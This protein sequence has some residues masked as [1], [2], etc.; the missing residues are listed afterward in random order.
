MEGHGGGSLLGGRA[1]CPRGQHDPRPRARRVPGV[2]TVSVAPA[3]LAAFSRTRGA[4]GRGRAEGT[5]QAECSWNWPECTGSGSGHPCGRRVR[6]QGAGGRK[7]AK[8][9]TCLPW[10]DSL[11]CTEEAERLL[12]HLWSSWLVV[13]AGRV[14]PGGRGG[15]GRTGESESRESYQPKGTPAALSS[16]YS[17]AP[18]PLT[19][20]PGRASP[21]C[22][23]GGVWWV[24]PCLVVKTVRA[25][26]DHL[27]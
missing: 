22:G 16:P 2:S 24:V 21:G 7:P 26:P 23:F 11:F 13:T 18:P 25:G 27:G 14:C 20:A 6:G 10:K 8:A 3:S 9:R 5:G 15:T 1:L 4:E 12:S 17:V 19:S